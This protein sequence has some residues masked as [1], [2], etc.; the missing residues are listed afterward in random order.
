MLPYNFAEFVKSP[1]AAFVPRDEVVMA[2]EGAVT[3][4]ELLYIYPI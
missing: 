3:W 2:A 1:L 4:A